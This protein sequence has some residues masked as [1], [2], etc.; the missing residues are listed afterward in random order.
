MVLKKKLFKSLIHSYGTNS[1]GTKKIHRV[2]ILPFT[3][4]PQPL[5]S[6]FWKQLLFPVSCVSFGDSLCGSK[7]F[8]M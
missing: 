6:P 3:P 7:Y 1:K 4:I 5:T 8:F 2:K